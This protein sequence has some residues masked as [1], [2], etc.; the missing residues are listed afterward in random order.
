MTDVTMVTDPWG[1]SR[2]ETARDRIGRLMA[3]TPTVDSVM[4]RPIAPAEPATQPPPM[5]QALQAAAAACG[6]DLAALVDSVAFM[7][8]VRA[9]TPADTAGLQ[10][11]VSD[12]LAQNPSLAIAPPRAGMKPNSAQGGSASGWASTPATPAERV[13]AQTQKITGQPLPPGS[14]GY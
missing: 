12:A 5:V 9:I 1:V 4:G 6:A 13:R 7:R 2:P 10:G 3:S 14:T 8:S 11:A